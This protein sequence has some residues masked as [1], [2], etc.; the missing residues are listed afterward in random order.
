M[1]SLSIYFFFLLFAQVVQSQ[2]ITIISAD[3]N[4]SIPSAHIV[5]KNISTQKE[6]NFVTDLEGK[7][8]LS[9]ILNGNSKIQLT[10]SFIGYQKIIDTLTNI[11][12]KIYYLKSEI[13]A[14]NEIIF[15]AQYAPNS[16]QK[17]VHKVK[18]IDNKKIQTMG[19][20]NLRD[21]LSNEMNVRIS[22]DNVLGSSMSLQGVSGQNVKIL[23]DG[24]PVT[25]RLNG[26]IDISQINMN[27]VEH[28]EIV[29]GP[30]SVNYGTDA[31]AGTINIITKKSQ[32]ETFSVSS[33][34]Y[35]ESIGQYNF[36][37]RI[38]YRKNKN[39]VTV[40]GGRNYFDG[41]NPTDKAFYIE[42]K[43]FADSTRYKSWKPKEQ[44]FGTLYYGLYIKD[45]K[46]GYTG[47]YFYEQITNKGLP[48]LPYQ[49]TAFDDYYNTYRLNNSL[50]LAGQMNKKYYTNILFA[51]NHYQ[52]IK[53]T[54]Y[55][56]L[57]T[58]DEILTVNSSDHDTIVFN[59]ITARGSIAT[60]KDSAKLNYEVGLDLNNEIGFG[61]RIK[62]KQQ[63]IGDYAIFCS[64][65]YKPF[66]K[67][68]LRPGARLI[69]NTVYKAPIIPSFNLRYE[70]SK[71]HTIRFSYARGFRSPSLKE[72]YFYFVDI[73]HNVIGNQELKAEQ[74]HNFNLSMSYNA[75]KGNTLWKT[76]NS[77]F[78]NYIEN[79]IS[80]A[81]LLGTQ[82]TYFNIDKYQTLGIQLQTELAWQHFKF[83]IG[84]A[85]IGRYN[86]LSE[87]YLSE[88]FTYTPEGKCNLFY[89]W[90]K[91]NITFA[92]FY[93]YTGELPSFAINTKNEI[94]KTKIYDYHTAD[95]SISK[96]FLEKKINISI[97]TK[98][99]FDVRN[100][101]GS[102]T[103][104]AHSSENNSIAIGMGRTYFMKLDINL[105]SKK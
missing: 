72:L 74:S 75:K 6:N 78:Y 82:Y 16:S 20:Q 81:Q 18:I 73:N 12:N 61:I 96:L 62:D 27:N 7:V 35:Y 21:V 47:D 31:L 32:K 19:A 26:N 64:A 28:I 99:I 85:Y 46:F 88:K 97:G 51:Y 10:I 55:K 37:G 87:E 52:R 58:L 9:T 39:I 57:T 86:Q 89:E 80:L 36:T 71:P 33:N 70:L 101:T 38:G 49:E 48:R 63:Q 95:I 98:N 41:W 2:T 4:Q 11:Q 14:L 77:F 42:Q 92:L 84:G 25:G 54:Y 43:H 1:K 66:S 13:V 69:Y 79:M 34:N 67:L 17:A 45:L 5:C 8:N 76:E 23:I 50:S 44:Y 59:N 53:N 91:K 40:S 93:K 56:D 103:G 60:T 15:T 24:V 94:Y 102:S 105:N 65:E 22:Q 100:I 3:D 29:E 104:S 68:T 83:T 30:L 90:H